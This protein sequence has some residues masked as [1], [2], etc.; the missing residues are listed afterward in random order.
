[1]NIKKN[2]D[3]FIS[4]LI[5]VLTLIAGIDILIYGELRSLIHLGN[6]RYFVGGVFILFGLAVLAAASLSL[7]KKNY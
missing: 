4:L 3:K 6:E 1:M 7:T 5:G 2:K